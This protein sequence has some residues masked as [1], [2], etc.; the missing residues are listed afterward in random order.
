MY[1]FLVR[2]DN[3]VCLDFSSLAAADGFGVP[4]FPFLREMCLFYL[5]EG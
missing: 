2:L 4:Q 1:L 5:E 3:I